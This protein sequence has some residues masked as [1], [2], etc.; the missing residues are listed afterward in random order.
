MLSHIEKKAR[1]LRGRIGSSETSLIQE[2]LII[3]LPT[4]SRMHCSK[5]DQGLPTE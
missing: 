4:I 3:L 2:L 5:I 1:H